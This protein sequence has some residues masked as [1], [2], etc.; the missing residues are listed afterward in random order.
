MSEQ[1]FFSAEIEIADITEDTVTYKISSPTVDRGLDR[2]VM[3]GCD[4]KNYLR[5]PI[6]LWGH[7][8]SIPAIATCSGIEV[9]PDGIY[10]KTKFHGLTELGEDIK[11]LAVGGILKA[12]SIGFIP[13]LW[14][15]VV[16]SGQ[17]IREFL[18]WELLEYSIVNVP[19]NPDALSLQYKSAAEIGE[20]KEISG[21]LYQQKAGR[22]LS[23][24]NEEALK[25]AIE[26]L[27]SVLAQVQSTPI[28][29]TDI[30]K[31]LPIS[32]EIPA[33]YLT[34]TEL[35]RMIFGGC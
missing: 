19:M 16:E 22:V 25:Q 17:N 9:M 27:Q 7:D 13:K 6:V 1:K 20:I 21:T 24:A 18:E 35:D 2:M 32:I 23:T 8:Y 10:A 33:E 14:R 30:T 11:K 5:N 28:V 34:D 31:E 4:Y 15:D 26:L 3:S 12:V 29:E